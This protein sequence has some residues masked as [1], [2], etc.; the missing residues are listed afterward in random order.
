MD[1]GHT[2]ATLITP[3]VIPLQKALAPSC[4]NISLAISTILDNPPSFLWRYVSKRE[5]DMRKTMVM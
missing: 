1:E 3:R 4:L 5:I 2:Y